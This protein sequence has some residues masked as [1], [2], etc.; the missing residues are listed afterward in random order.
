MGRLLVVQLC[1]LGIAI[2]AGV[3]LAIWMD[4]HR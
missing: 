2:L 1:M 3:W 4:L